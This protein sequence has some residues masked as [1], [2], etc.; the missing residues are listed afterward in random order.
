ME[1]VV[2]PGA[3]HDRIEVTEAKVSNGELL[4]IP[5]ECINYN[6]ILLSVWS[7]K[8]ADHIF[9]MTIH[10]WKSVFFI[11]KYLLSFNFN[12]I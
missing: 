1:D 7:R 11:E 9:S 5:F 6:N 3:K 4:I 10:K 2:L 12:I 8:I